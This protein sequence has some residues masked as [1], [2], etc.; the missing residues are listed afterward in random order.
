M[1]QFTEQEY[2]EIRAKVE[3]RY[4]KRTE[5]VMHLVAYVFINIGIHMGLA[6]LV[7]LEAPIPFLVTLLW[8][9]GLVMHGVQVLFETGIWVHAQE[10]AI[11]REIEMQLFYK[12]GRVPSFMNKRKNDTDFSHLHIGYDGELVSNEDDT[13]AQQETNQNG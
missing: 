7:G 13:F 3:D 9:A 1:G 12:E 4:N 8:G 2:R 10:K 6:R 11:Q 5:F